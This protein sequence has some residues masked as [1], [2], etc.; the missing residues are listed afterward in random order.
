MTS[1]SQ[2]SVELAQFAAVQA[3][4]QDAMPIEE[5]L[6]REGIDESRWPEA[7]KSALLDIASSAAAFKAYQRA[8]EAAQDE[9]SRTVS[10]LHDDLA[11]W[12]AYMAN[13]NIQT[14]HAGGGENAGGTAWFDLRSQSHGTALPQTVGAFN[15][16]SVG[17]EHVHPFRN[18]ADAPKPTTFEVAQMQASRH[19]VGRIAAA[20]GTSPHNVLGDGQTAL[21]D[22]KLGRKVGCPGSGYDWFRLEDAGLATPTRQFRPPAGHPFAET[23]QVFDHHF[24]AGNATITASSPALVRG[25]LVAMLR[26]LG[27]HIPEPPTFDAVLEAATA[28]QV[29]HFGGPRRRGDLARVQTASHKP[30]VNRLTVDTI[31]GVFEARGGF[32]F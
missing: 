3:A 8:L 9:L 20:F 7:R 1:T 17:V 15:N 5:V 22:H 19:L 13:E 10:P 27:Y 26:G 16:I 23:Y 12:I 28:F 21:E 32:T 31:F 25:T 6:E 18:R 11:A 14:L 29:R 2:A 30:I 4:E 24:A